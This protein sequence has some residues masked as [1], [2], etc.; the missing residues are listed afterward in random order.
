MPIVALLTC[1]FVG[2]VLGPQVLVSE[3]RL[4]RREAAL[5]TVIVRYV[6]P[7]FIVLILV[8]SL[9]DALRIASF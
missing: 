8:S 5:F 9:L 7:V 3:A 2:Y 4:K 1:V 6:A